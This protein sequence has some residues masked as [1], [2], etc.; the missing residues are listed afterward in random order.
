MAKKRRKTARQAYKNP[1]VKPYW[2]ADLRELWLGDT[3]IKRYRRPAPIAHWI[4]TAFQEQN[5]KRRIDDPLIP[6]PNGNPPPDRL[7]CQVQALNRSLKGTPL[8]FLMDGTGHG[9][10][11]HPASL[12][13][14]PCLLPRDSLS[15]SPSLP[16]HAICSLPS[17]TV[18]L[19][20]WQC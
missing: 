17:T 14:V 18:V 5:W 6:L 9:L 1:K 4:F 10:R 7:R 2:D 19:P 15:P 8:R 16:W 20:L 13:P 3:L 12:S 11:W